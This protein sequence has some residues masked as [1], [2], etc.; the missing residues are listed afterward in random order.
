MFKRSDFGPCTNNNLEGCHSRVK[1]LAGKAH[2]NIFE[3]VE[4][5]MTE[6]FHREASI[7]Q[8]AAGRT[9]RRGQAGRERKKGERKY[10]T[11]LMQETI[12]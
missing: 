7:L 1:T 10:W 6:Q 12:P 2:L 9:V 8:L 5:F 11:N 3:M 4:L